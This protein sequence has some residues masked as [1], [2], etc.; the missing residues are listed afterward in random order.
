FTI[1]TLVG[2]VSGFWGGKV[3]LLL[4][5]VVEVFES[6]PVLLLL[7]TLVAFVGASLPLLVVFA[8]LLSWMGIS[9][10]VRADFLR[11]RKWEFVEAARAQGVGTLRI[12]YR[13]I[14]PNALTSLITFS[15][16]E[17]AASIYALAA[18]DYL[19]LGLPPPTPSWG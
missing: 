3:D 4:L 14:L 19:G 1:G 18:L 2:A 9:R 6:L 8:V 5:Q 16:T 13:H 7:L 17:M 11:L 15:P 10:Y 12:L